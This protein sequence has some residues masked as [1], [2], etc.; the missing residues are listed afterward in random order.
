MA[1]LERLLETTTDD[2]EA[3]EAHLARIDMAEIEGLMRGLPQHEHDDAAM[4]FVR[5]VLGCPIEGQS[6]ASAAYEQAMP[7]RRCVVDLLLSMVLEKKLHYKWVNELSM[8]FMVLVDELRDDADATRSV[9]NEIQ[10]VL[11]AILALLHAALN[12][13]SAVD[14]RSFQSILD[15]VPYLVSL[16]PPSSDTS[17]LVEQL[18]QLPWAAPTLHLVLGF[19]RGCTFLTRA[20]H[21]KLQTLVR[22]TLPSLSSQ[23]AFGFWD[24]S[25]RAC[26]ELSDAHDDLMWIS[27]SREMLAFAPPSLERDLDYLFQTLFQYSPVYV[28]RFHKVLRS[29]SAA[30]T[31]LDVLVVLHAMHAT[32]PLFKLSIAKPESEHKQL[33]KTLQRHLEATAVLDIRPLLRFSKHWKAL[34]LLDAAVAWLPTSAAI[35]HHTFLIVFT[36]VPELRTEV[37]NLLLSAIDA[38]DQ[39]LHVLE[40]LAMDQTQLLAT[41]AHQLQ[42]RVAHLFSTSVSCGTRLL[43][44]LLPLTASSA[45]ESFVM[46]FLRKQLVAPLPANQMAAITLWCDLLQRPTL[47]S[48]QQED[49]FTCF[50]DVLHMPSAELKRHLLERLPALLASTSVAPPAHIEAACRRNLACFVDFTPPNAPT[51]QSA[52][53]ADAAPVFALLLDVLPRLSPE[54]AAYV[55]ALR[56]ALGQLVSSAHCIA[57]LNQPPTASS[58]VRAAVYATC[59]D[60]AH[61]V[62]VARLQCTLR[63]VH[64]SLPQGQLLGA[65]DA[66]SCCLQHTML[67]L[68]ALEKQSTHLSVDDVAVAVRSTVRLY[69]ELV[70]GQGS[71]PLLHDDNDNDQVDL[72][73]TCRLKPLKT[74]KLSDVLGAILRLWV[75]LAKTNAHFDYR[76][77]LACWHVDAWEPVLAAFHEQLTHLLSGSS[78]VYLALI[79]VE[80]LKLVHAQLSPSSHV[81]VADAMYLLLCENAVASPNLLRAVLSMSFPSNVPLERL[82][83]VLREAQAPDAD[84]RIS[85]A[86]TAKHKRLRPAVTHPL[87]VS[88]TTRATA[89]VLAMKHVE[90][91]LHSWYAQL[92]SNGSPS[93]PW[94]NVHAMLLEAF[95]APRLSW[96]AAGGVLDSVLRIGKCVLP[97]I[98][99]GSAIVA[100]IRDLV[101]LQL[102]L[103]KAWQLYASAT[104]DMTTKMDVFLLEAT[105][106]L[107]SALKK[108]HAL[109]PDDRSIVEDLTQRIMQH[110]QS[111]SEMTKKQTTQLRQQAQEL[112]TATKQRRKHRLRSRHEYIDECLREEGG[113][114]AFAD[115][116]DFIA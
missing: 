21:H 80:W 19:A 111:M 29:S 75:A 70:Q 28:Q 36:D 56:R 63:R 94:A 85:T 110:V 6:L 3:V 58:A 65:L 113:D 1:S 12:N 62:D 37:V 16:L 40:K 77:F 25:V 83:A 102:T 81:D 9:M 86:P 53:D 91:A 99:G 59:C 31:P 61:S 45:F 103:V 107:G 48:R 71:I 74:Y 35:A 64:G 87:L 27:L 43:H 79:L 15:S 13:F 8:A 49:I 34:V 33:Q 52:I 73:A 66:S 50:H 46:V 39:A 108:K 72:V 54:A 68:V 22:T 2:I 96:K 105:S 115:L 82:I 18:L 78:H 101:L 5:L 92:S 14:A 69:P 112:R 106:T 109:A 104:V 7:R 10:S 116:E 11:Q 60:V 30:W 42:D 93:T 24:D 51:L 41:V 100:I 55:D 26:Y 57:Y 38:T 4:A 20:H 17:I 90:G 67:G 88:E 47:S 76:A 32:Q 114:D 89:Y 84:D 95:V 98:H 97:A 44:S 23:L